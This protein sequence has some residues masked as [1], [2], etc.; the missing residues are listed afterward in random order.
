MAVGAQVSWGANASATMVLTLFSPNIPINEVAALAMYN[1][2]LPS[3]WFKNNH[4]PVLYK[5]LGEWNNVNPPDYFALWIV[6]PSGHNWTSH[7]PT[8]I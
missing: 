1:E 8:A 2:F 7:L 3:N 5:A 6:K 4:R